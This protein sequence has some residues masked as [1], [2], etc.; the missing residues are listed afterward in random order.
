MHSSTSSSNSVAPRSGGIAAWLLAVGLAAAA[1]GGLELFA[2][3]HGHVP[4]VADDAALWAHWRGRVGEGGKN[5]VVLLGGSR[6]EL[7]F[8]MPEF[9]TMYPDHPVVQL[10]VNGTQPVAALRDL[11][12]DEAFRGLVICDVTEQSLEREYWD[13]QEYLVR[14]YRAGGPLDAELNLRA[15][16]FVQTH[17]AMAGPFLNLAKIGAVAASSRRF[18]APYHVITFPDRSQL[19]DFSKIDD[20]RAFHAQHVKRV[21][22]T[23]YP[24]TTPAQWLAGALE[25]EAFAQRIRDRGGNVVFLRMPMG[26]VLRKSIDDRYP[27]K[28]YWEAWKQRTKSVLIVADDYPELRDFEVPDEAHLDQRDTP[29]FTRALACVVGRQGVLPTGACESPAARHPAQGPSANGRCG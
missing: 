10:A 24:A 4:S 2:R 3:A 13:S 25:V 26:P 11:A 28:D 22:A 20:L 5:A 1:I 27:R 23:R 7:G 12:Q 6:I 14:Q 29:R 15:S 19:A 16:L 8:S 17:L 21:Q 18:R 9:R